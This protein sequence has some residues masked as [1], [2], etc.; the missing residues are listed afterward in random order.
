MEIRGQLHGV[1]S[2]LPLCGFQELNSVYQACM[3]NA[4]AF[5]AIF[6]D[7]KILTCIGQKVLEKS[8]DI[9][10]KYKEMSHVISRYVLAF[11]LY[12]KTVT[13]QYIV[14]GDIAVKSHRCFLCFCVD[15]IFNLTKHMVWLCKIFLSVFL[16]D[17]SLEVAWF[18][19]RR[20]HKKGQ[21]GVMCLRTHG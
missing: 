12:F 20:L 16:C 7:P 3:A 15:F 4:F 18:V 2:H 5:S 6:A 8:E 21:R 13:I 11:S 1:D 9:F 14:L 19:G 17:V 10:L